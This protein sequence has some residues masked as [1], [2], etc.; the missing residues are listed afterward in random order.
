MKKHS[1]VKVLSSKRVAFWTV[2]RPG[3]GRVELDMLASCS[4]V[5]GG[6]GGADFQTSVL[7]T[8][9]ASVPRVTAITT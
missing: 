4:R 2:E 5:I 7:L 9:K 6:F 8:V 1:Y 3:L